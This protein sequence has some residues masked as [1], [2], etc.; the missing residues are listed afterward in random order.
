MKKKKKIT[1]SQ[2]EVE[3]SGNGTTV[4][5][6]TTCLNK[7]VIV[8]LKFSE[9]CLYTAL[10]HWLSPCSSPQNISKISALHFTN[11]NIFVLP[12]PSYL[13]P[14]PPP[15]GIYSVPLY[16]PRVRAP[17]PP[18]LGIYPAPQYM[19]WVRAYF[20]VLKATVLHIH[21]QTVTVDIHANLTV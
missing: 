7:V 13:Y 15:C 6:N 3:M 21:I 4:T 5:E 2:W 14:P 18:P 9:E 16:I 8:E 11:L 1:K 19:S 10:P 12:H 17:L 20:C